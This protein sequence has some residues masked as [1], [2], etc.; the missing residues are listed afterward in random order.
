M[1]P[2]A[3][4]W[5]NPQGTNARV[6]RTAAEAASFI[7]SHPKEF[8]SSKYDATAGRYIVRL[9]EKRTFA[10]T[11][12]AN[13]QMH[14]KPAGFCARQHSLMRPDRTPKQI[15]GYNGSMLLSR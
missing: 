13:R 3:Q 7:A 15:L 14:R 4:A 10:S 5:H 11:R 8:Y 6:F 1:Q 9:I 2:Q 12:D